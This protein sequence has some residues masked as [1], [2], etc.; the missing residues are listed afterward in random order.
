MSQYHP[1]RQPFFTTPTTGRLAQSKGKVVPSF[2][3]SCLVSRRP[4]N[5]VGALRGFF[6]VILDRERWRIAHETYPI[7]FSLLH[8]VASVRIYLDT[9]LSS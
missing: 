6:H 5:P 2:N 1:L 4:V 3:E 9:Y 8:N 7:I